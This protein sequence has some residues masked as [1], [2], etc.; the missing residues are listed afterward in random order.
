MCFLFNGIR[1]TFTTLF[2]TTVVMDS[3][4]SQ[5]CLLLQGFHLYQEDQEDHG[6]LEDQEHQE[7]QKVPVESQRGSGL[8]EL[9]MAGFCQVLINT[10]QQN[11][12]M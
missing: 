9:H 8:T 3:S 12:L 11:T 4:N 10:A 6:L 1:T 5:E 2:C 7:S